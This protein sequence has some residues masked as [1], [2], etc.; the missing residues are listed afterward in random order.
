[1]NN[2]IT[3]EQLELQIKE[4]QKELE[5]IQNNDN[6]GK[7]CPLKLIYYDHIKFLI[8]NCIVIAE[9]TKFSEFFNRQIER[10]TRVLYWHQREKSLPVQNA[11]EF[12]NLI[13]TR[14]PELRGFFDILFRSMN[15]DD[16]NKK[17]QQQLRQKIMMLCYQMASLRNKQ[18]S[19]AKAAIGLYMTGAD[20]STVGINTLSNM[21][22][23]ATY[24]TVYN[25]KKEIVDAH[26][27]NVQKYIAD[28][29][30]NLEN[31]ICFV[32]YEYLN[33]NININ[34][35]F[36]SAKTTFNF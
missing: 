23:S 26:E 31:L 14:D 2:V 22:I 29:V 18:V 10:M 27:Q 4:F 11:D 8:I 25:N 34:K 7:V 16:K 1:M 24:Q 21:G 33:I 30:R 15:P 32:I 13:E 3:I 6:N 9:S 36:Y 5:K 35:F 12:V 17:T 28:H 20:A 19:G